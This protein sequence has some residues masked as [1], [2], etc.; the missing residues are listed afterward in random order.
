MLAVAVVMTVVMFG[1]QGYHLYR[2]DQVASH[3][4][5]TTL[6]EAVHS[7]GARQIGLIEDLEHDVLVVGKSLTR[8]GIADWADR[9]AAASAETQAATTAA[10]T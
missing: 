1:W 2:T 10:S 3:E 5:T 4:Q 6:V 8:A 9:Y 7:A